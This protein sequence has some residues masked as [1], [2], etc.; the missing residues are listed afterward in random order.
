MSSSCS[1]SQIWWYHGIHPWSQHLT[2]DLAG[3]LAP[4]VSREFS[5]VPNRDPSLDHVSVKYGWES[6]RTT[7]VSLCR[8][9][10]RHS[11]HPRNDVDRLNPIRPTHCGRV[12]IT[13]Q[14]GRVSGI[15]RYQPI[16]GPE[17]PSVNSV[18]FSPGHPG[19]ENPEGI[20][21]PLLTRTSPLP[22]GRESVG[23]V[24]NPKNRVF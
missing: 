9:R 6:R 23:G 18:S 7:D 17:S 19:Y 10:D 5:G 22:E 2:M 11:K 14:T 15:H 1:E 3:K 16:P 4:R 24:K 13:R 21:P 20:C 8:Q 12:A